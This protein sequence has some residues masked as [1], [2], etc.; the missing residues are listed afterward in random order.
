MSQERASPLFV[1]SLFANVDF[2]VFEV[3]IICAT[4]TSTGMVQSFANDRFERTTDETSEQYRRHST[5]CSARGRAFALQR[6]CHPGTY[7][8]KLFSA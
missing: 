5:L 1:L 8:S 6:R 4:R 7:P 2:H 3:Q